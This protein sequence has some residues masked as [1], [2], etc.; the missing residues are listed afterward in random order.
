MQLWQACKQEGKNY[1]NNYYIIIIVYWNYN[2]GICFQN[3]S[4]MDGA[5]FVFM[6]HWCAKI[7]LK[8]SNKQRQGSDYGNC[9]LQLL[10]TVIKP[11]VP[12]DVLFTVGYKNELNWLDR[13]HLVLKMKFENHWN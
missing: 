3:A 2:C 5:C 1:N 6:E 11:V 13:G 7:C 12:M 9:T 4:W 10:Y 8:P